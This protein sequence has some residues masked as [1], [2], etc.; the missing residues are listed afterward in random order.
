MWRTEE[1]VDVVD[2]RSKHEL[3]V[4][5]RATS[6]KNE[7]EDER[8][9]VRNMGGSEAS[10]ARDAVRVAVI[11]IHPVASQ[12]NLSTHDQGASFCQTCLKSQPH[13]LTCRSLGRNCC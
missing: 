9:R 12:C 10:L 6:R 2:V 11:G 3:E 13:S 5:E 8:V 4:S 1:L 7:D